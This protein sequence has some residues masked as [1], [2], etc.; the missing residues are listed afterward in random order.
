MIAGMWSPG[1][2][3]G[4]SAVQMDTRKRFDYARLWTF[5][6]D[7]TVA[8]SFLIHPDKSLI[9]ARYIGPTTVQDMRNLATEIWS[10]PGYDPTYSG[11]LDYREA[12][13]DA[14][15]DGIHE[16]CQYFCES[17]QSS[18]G[19]CSILSTCPLETALNTIFMQRME[20]HNIIMVCCT[21]D[22]ACRFLGVWLP[23][24]LQV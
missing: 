3:L 7:D 5:L 1:R 23:D 13:L 14:S 15:P 4:W 18:R 12:I 17:A 20:C 6:P 22:T 21:W 16:V 11:I 10:H 2:R 19:K 24:H 8:Y 9:V